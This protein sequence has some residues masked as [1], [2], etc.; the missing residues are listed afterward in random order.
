MAAAEPDPPELLCPDCGHPRLPGELRCGQCQM[1]HEA[2]ADVVAALTPV[3]PLLPQFSL[4]TL[5]FS[6]TWIA[7][8]LGSLK[9]S[10]CIGMLL[11]FLTMPALLRTLALGL[12]DREA[13]LPIRPRKRLATFFAS[14]AIM[15]LVLIVSGGIFAASLWIV[16]SVASGPPF[17]AAIHTAAAILA[18]TVGVFAAFAAAAA[19]LWYTRWL[20]A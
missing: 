6:V 9:L 20:G 19:I 16:L 4:A 3:P 11:I 7:I 14:L 17:P 1:R 8:C 15:L 5:F 18:M 2:Q 13:G 10:P 12:R